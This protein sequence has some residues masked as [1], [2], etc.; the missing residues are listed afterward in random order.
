MSSNPEVRA[1]IPAVRV[2][3]LAALIFALWALQHPYPGIYHD[4]QLYTIQAL[5]R[6]LP[7]ELANDVFLR[8]GSQDKYTFFGP[9][10][11]MAIRMV[12]TGPAAAILT[13]VSQAVF[14][15]ALLLLARRVLPSRLAWLGVGLVC[16]IPFTY[17]ARKVFFV[18][19]DFITPRLLAEALVIAGL[20]GL[21]VGRYRLAMLAAVFAALV[22][23]IVAVTGLALAVFLDVFTNRQRTVT[24]GLGIAVALALLAMLAARGSQL[25]F[26]E[27]WWN[28]IHDGLPYLFPLEWRKADWARVVLVVA[29]LFAGM[30][31][32]PAANAQSL[33]RAAL[34]VTV[35][36]MLLSIVGSDLSRV[37]LVTQM[38][39]WR[40]LWLASVIALLLSPH[41][42]LQLWN[43]GV[44]ARSALAAILAAFL[45]A[46]ERFAL[47]AAGCAA[48]LVLVSDRV[49]TERADLRMVL[50]GMYALLALA[51]VINLVSGTIVARAR[52]DQSIVPGWMLALRGV[53]GTG[54]L[55]AIALCVGGWM[56]MQGRRAVMAG[57]ASAS[58]A[59]ALL[60]ATTLWPQW[61]Y[62]PFSSA[63]HAAFAGWRA[64]IPP[65]TEVVW[66]EF[67][68]ASWVLLE[69]PNYISQQQTASA[70][71]SRE[72]A[73]ALSDRVT[74]LLPFLK[75][76]TTSLAVGSLTAFCDATRQRFVVARTQF[77]V[78]PIA[79]APDDLPAELR[80]WKLYACDSRLAAGITP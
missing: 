55:P 63:N 66:F 11:A 58:A 29:V 42:V 54:L 44:L 32:L 17:G 71:F 68:T 67:P 3:A 31:R 8:H 72:A 18:M 24:I 47:P 16:V 27:E 7:M 73:R 52:F 46:D 77:E 38:Q 43:G 64:R 25:V 57:T 30:R 45:M 70:V 36:G 75:P 80:D 20:A 37:V 50:Y 41:I 74:P 39:P 21:F 65:G 49:S 51:V 76:G 78:A 22:H 9:L 26:D 15:I 14:A 40:V 19:E 56:I 34:I 69:R 79:V 6:V 10:Y 23:P 53:C 1:W 12:G 13:F 62:T 48:V 5:A 4:S 2:A 33:C 28:M 61:A 60:F 35:G 59:M